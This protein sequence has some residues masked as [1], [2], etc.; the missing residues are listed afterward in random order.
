[1]TKQTYYDLVSTGHSIEY[2]RIA[3]S[4]FL[5]FGRTVF[6]VHAD[7]YKKVYSKFFKELEDAIDEFVIL[8]REL[9]GNA[10]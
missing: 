2:R 3:L 6:Q 8:K 5:R 10:K 9:Y 1:M 4:P 7:T